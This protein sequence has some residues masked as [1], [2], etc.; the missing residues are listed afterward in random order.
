[1]MS[2]DLCPSPLVYQPLYRWMVAGC[3][4]VIVHDLRILLRCRPAG[5]S[6][7]GHLGWATIQSTPESEARAG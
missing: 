3:F 6:E 1:M 7:R 5:C 2:N 4:E